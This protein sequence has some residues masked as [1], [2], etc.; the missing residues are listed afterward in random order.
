MAAQRAIS[1]QRR[2]CCVVKLPSHMVVSFV[3]VLARPPYGGVR[4]MSAPT[5]P[6]AGTLVSADL[7]EQ[8]NEIV[9][10]FVNAMMFIRR[11]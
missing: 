11:A 7:V 2:G 1:R 9:K 10:A 6:G 4:V 8:A 3:E 5:S